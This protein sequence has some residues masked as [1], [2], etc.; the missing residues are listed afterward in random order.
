MHEEI[1]SNN[2]VAVSFIE[3]LKEYNVN[4]IFGTTGAGMAELQDALSFEGYPLWIQSLHEFPAVSFA[5]GYSLAAEK[6]GVTMLD[7]IVGIQN[8]IGALYSSYLN[9]APIL[10]LS[11]RDAP[12][13]NIGNNINSHYSSDHLNI[14][15]PWVKWATNI[16]AKETI[17]Y[18]LAKALYLSNLEPRGITMLTLRHDV[19]RQKQKKINSP[20]KE[21]YYNFKIPDNE[22]IKKISDLLLTYNKP[23][24]LISHA[25]RNKNYVYSIVSFAEKYGLKVRERRYFMNYPSNNPLHTGFIG[26]EMPPDFKDDDL[27]ILMELGFLPGSMIDPELKKI[28]FTAD[29][30]NGKEVYIGGDYGSETLFNSLDIE[31]DLGPTLD[32]IIAFKEITNEDL[33]IIC[34]RKH[35]IQEEHN[36]LISFWDGKG[37]MEYSKEHMNP[38]SLGFVINKYW[39]KNFTLINGELGYYN[40]L[41]NTIH[42]DMP[43]SYFS[44][45]SAHLGSAMGMAGGVFLG[46]NEINYINGINDYNPVFCITGDGDAIFSN[47]NSILWSAKHYGLG[48]IFIIINNGAWRVEWP[49]FER[50]ENKYIIK[51]KDTK[52][53][54]LDNPRTDFSKIAE[55]Y[56]IL[57][58][59]VED[60]QTFEKFLLQAINQSKHGEP[61]LIDFIMEQFKQ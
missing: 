4:F 39:E 56:K 54:N 43:G 50:T 6:V 49:Y 14:V 44:N 46:K 38:I 12:G 13:I 8:A 58:K 3:K 59:R 11:S 36:K 57:S 34:E 28:N 26:G 37:L 47:L 24:I 60:I 30:L 2:T 41:V 16:E 22:T 20:T 10:I 19:M 33:K 31:C 18:D 25:G 42:L 5:E 17:N 45:P 55:S 52:F 61:V 53:V 27:L 21:G 32:K 7:R 15:R 1:N 35:K 29:I 40:E 23:E 9:F 51:N 48:I